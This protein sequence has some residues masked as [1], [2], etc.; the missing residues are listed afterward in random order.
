MMSKARDTK[1]NF[2]HSGWTQQAENKISSSTKRKWA[3]E[4]ARKSI[5]LSLIKS[6]LG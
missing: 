1:H 5:S 3:A 6:G 2:Q 4:L